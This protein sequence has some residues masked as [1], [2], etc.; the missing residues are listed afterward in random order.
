[1]A[2]ACSVL[3]TAPDCRQHA[4]IHRCWQSKPLLQFFHNTFSIPLRS[5]SLS[6][7]LRIHLPYFVCVCFTFSITLPSCPIHKAWASSCESISQIPSPRIQLEDFVLGNPSSRFHLRDSTFEIS[8]S[9]FRRPDFIIQVSSSRFHH[10]DFIAQSSSSAIHLPELFVRS[11][12]CRVL[13]AEFALQSPSCRVS[14]A[15][16][17]QQSLPHTVHLPDFISKPRFLFSLWSKSLHTLG[18]HCYK[19]F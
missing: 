12:S 9:R 15:G 3:E 4:C 18:S 17:H 19:S 10:P 5:Q 6:P 14:L 8:S 11:L 1:M 13:L 16:F 2:V 7:L